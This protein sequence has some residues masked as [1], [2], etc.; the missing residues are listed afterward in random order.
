MNT[1][2]ESM[3]GMAASLRD[4]ASRGA[5]QVADAVERARSEAGPA[6]RELAHDAQDMARSGAEAVRERSVQLRDASTDYVRAHPLQAMLIVAGAG[7]ALALLANMLT[8]R[9]HTH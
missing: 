9:H 4:T 3:A 5:H 6:L 2:Q 8:H 1:T 7:A